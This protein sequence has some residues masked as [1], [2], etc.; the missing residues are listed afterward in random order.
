[1][2]VLYP[3]AVA[4][5]FICGGVLDAKP[6]E[7]DIHQ[8]HLA[9]VLPDDCE[10]FKIKMQ[11]DLERERE[12]V[13]LELGPFLKREVQTLAS[14]QEIPL[15]RP[16]L[17]KK[18]S[19][20]S[21]FFEAFEK[22]KRQTFFKQHLEVI[23]GEKQKEWSFQEVLAK[24]LD[25]HPDLK[26]AKALKEAARLKKASFSDYKKSQQAF[27]QVQQSIIRQVANVYLKVLK[28]KELL[29]IAE[30]KGKE[31]LH[32]AFQDSKSRLLLEIQMKKREVDLENAK[33]EFYEVV[34]LFPRDLKAL[35]LREIMKKAPK[36]I[37]EAHETAFSHHPS[38]HQ[39]YYDVEA[40]RKSNK[41]FKMPF[42]LEAWEQAQKSLR[43]KVLKDVSLAYN[44]LQH[45]V[46][47]LGKYQ[48]HREG[49]RK[50]YQRQGL[51]ENFEG[52]FDAE[53]DF[54]EARY[55]ALGH[56]FDLYYAMG[57]FRF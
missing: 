46:F 2:K 23:Q 3:G 47:S 41:R 44:H 51:P 57:D 36:S 45:A 12:K 39:M 15:E 54:V 17:L 4:F 29:S 28:S 56:I 35:S 49:A 14:L 48:E 16:R 43:G 38:L 30:V 31:S 5:L 52:L 32:G 34:R 22:L 55:N 11:K 6:I 18:D 42:E 53:N 40:V 21:T 26:R 20:L 19:I 33:A 37:R 24:A 8:D 13:I 9:I 50:A 7:K 1:M 10:L 25:R 27:R